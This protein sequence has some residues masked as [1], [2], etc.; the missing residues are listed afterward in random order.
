MSFSAAHLCI[1]EGE[2]EAPAVGLCRCPAMW[3]LPP[4]L[5]EMTLWTRTGH[6]FDYNTPIEET[7]SSQS[8][9]GTNWSA[10]NLGD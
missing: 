6:R 9:L 3:V 5:V 8:S 4:Q 7:V 1:R 10:T 2:S